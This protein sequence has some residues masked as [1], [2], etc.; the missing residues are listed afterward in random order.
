MGVASHPSEALISPAESVV[1]PSQ[2]RATVLFQEALATAVVAAPTIAHI[3]PTRAAAGDTITITGTNLAGATAVLFPNNVPG[4]I[5]DN[6][7]TEITVKVPINVTQGSIM[8]TTP[9]GT[10]TSAERFEYD[11]VAIVLAGIQG[12]FGFMM[13]ATKLGAGIAYDVAEYSDYQ[14]NA[15]G[16]KYANEVKFAFDGIG[17]IMSFINATIYTATKKPHTPRQIIDVTMQQYLQLLPRIKDAILV[18]YW[19][20]IGKEFEFREQAAWAESAFGGIS[21]MAIVASTILQAQEDPFPVSQKDADALLG[22]KAAHNMCAS[23]NQ[24]LNGP[25]TAITRDMMK[26]DPVLAAVKLTLI[27]VRGGI[28]TLVLPALTLARAGINLAVHEQFLD[29]NAGS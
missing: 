24:M 20:K 4:K 16:K 15:E 29:G 26:S 23:L 3:S 19:H 22:L 12:M 21:Y 18:F 17:Y 6:S 1:S 27:G 13:G 7:D 28:A 11:G 25:K 10:A 9:A 2:L 8:V 5:H 14:G